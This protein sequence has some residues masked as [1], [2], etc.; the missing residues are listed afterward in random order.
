MNRPAEDPVSVDEL[1]DDPMKMPPPYWRSGGA[2]FH[3][4]AALRGIERRL[5]RLPA[6][7]TR[8]DVELAAYDKKYRTKAMRDASDD[9]RWRIISRPFG[10]EHEIKLSADIA[11]L[12]SAIE[13][14]DRVNSFCV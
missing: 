8:V 10:I 9:E 3:I 12:M 7:L 14:E 5:K 6:V 11:C 4:E 2:I 1:P 13:A